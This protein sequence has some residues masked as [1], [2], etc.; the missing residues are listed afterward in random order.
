MNRLIT[1][2]VFIFLSLSTVFAQELPLRPVHTYSIVARDSVTGDIGVAVQS[3]WFS[4]GTLVTWAEAGVG[5]VAT[6]SFVEM[7]YGPLGLELM[8]AG[9]TADQA[10]QA[11][12]AVDSNREVRQVA[13]VDIHGNVAVH[14]GNKCIIEAGHIKGK[15]F[16]V[17]ANMME[18]NSVWPAMAKAYSSTKGDLIDKFMAALEAA[19]AEGGDIRGKQSAAM[20]IV[21]GKTAGVPWSEKII[22]LRIEDHKQPIKELKRLIKVHRAYQHMNKGDEYFTNGD[23]NMALQE[24]AAAKKLYPENLEVIYWQA[25]TM[26]N[27]GKLEDA[28]PLFKEVFSK[29]KNWMELTKRLPHSDLLPDDPQLI[30]KILSVGK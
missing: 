23:V 6:Q 17:Q 21:P 29:D 4:V 28:L 18:K 20:L 2:I 19:Q 1:V 9:K 5:A 14:T 26:A 10:L 24:Y 25:V 15:Q 30:K 13:M 8:R 12:L 27:A 11:L 22:D 3:N 16:T 7:S